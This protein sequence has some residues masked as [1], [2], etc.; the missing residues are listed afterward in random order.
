MPGAIPTALA[1]QII[2]SCEKLCCVTNELNASC[3]INIS[4]AKE[5]ASRSATSSISTFRF[6]CPKRM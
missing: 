4:R 1:K 2:A 6:R 3:G 5:S